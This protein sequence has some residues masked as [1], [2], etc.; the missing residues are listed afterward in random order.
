MKHLFSNLACLIILVSALSFTFSLK[1]EETFK[2]YE[3]SD[4]AIDVVIPAIGKDLPTLELCISGIREN[5]PQVRRVFVVSKKPLT[6]SAEWIDEAIFP[7]TKLDVAM[8]LTRGNVNQAKSYMSIKGSR[9]GWY[10]QQLLKFYAC[11]CIPGIS[12]NLLILDGDA[13]FLNPV[14][15]VKEDGG[16]L[17]NVGDEHHPPYFEHGAKLIPGFRRL[18][19]EYSGICHHMLLQK[20]VL[21]DLFSVVEKVHQIDF[22]R[23]FCRC[24]DLDKIQLPGA[25]EYEI[26]FNFVFASSMQMEIR[27]LKWRNSDCL[28]KLQYYKK[29][30]YHYVSFHSYAR[31]IKHEKKMERKLVPYREDML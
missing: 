8:E 6:A 20:S 29:E 30:G 28:S 19:P 1:G 13:V 24:V 31:K 22:W 17:Y 27:P 26:Y 3:L 9:A 5:C 15:F 7:F 2:E 14:Q 18:W 16:S 4:E 11:F 12:S 25:S 10:Y 23:A 21:I